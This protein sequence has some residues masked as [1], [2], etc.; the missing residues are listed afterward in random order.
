MNWHWFS[1]ILSYQKSVFPKQSL[2]WF[3][4]QVHTGMKNQLAFPAPPWSRC[5]H[6]IRAVFDPIKDHPLTLGRDT[7]TGSSEKRG[8]NGYS[9]AACSRRVPLYQS[10]ELSQLFLVYYPWSKAGYSIPDIGK[11]LSHFLARKWIFSWLSVFSWPS[12]ERIDTQGW[13]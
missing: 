11:V 7:Q 4:L 9:L 1:H 8:E 2:L 13:P 12:E 3:V 5:C 6:G 10:G